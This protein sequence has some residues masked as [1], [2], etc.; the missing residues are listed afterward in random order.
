MQHNGGLKG[1]EAS[2]FRDLEGGLWKG[3]WFLK[4]LGRFAR[5]E[6]MQGH[7]AF[8]SLSTTTRFG[9]RGSN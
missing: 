5:A 8:I 9:G 6:K 4:W 2:G 1:E 3:I 7:A